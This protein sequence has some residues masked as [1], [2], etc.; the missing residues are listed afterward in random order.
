V[1]GAVEF[2][3][4]IA[5]QTLFVFLLFGAALGATL[6]LVLL[7]DSAR[8]LRWNERLS[9]WVSTR[10]ATQ[11][12]DRPRDIKRHVYR[13][14]R[15][16]GVLVVAGAAYCLDVLTF[17]FRPGALARAFR[18]LASPGALEIAFETARLFL[19]AGNIAALVAGIVLCLRPSLLKGFERWADRSYGSLAANAALDRMHFHPDRWVS[20]HPRLTGA[21]VLAGSGFILFSLGLRPLI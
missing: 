11:G 5:G 4:G 12:L 8:A 10:E 15:V 16:I 9:R 3:V 7:L 17:G 19:I 14:H 2:L 13:A 21:L 18:D 1:R 20:R 6:G